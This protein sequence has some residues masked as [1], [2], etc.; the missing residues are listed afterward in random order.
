MLGGRLGSG[1]APLGSAGQLPQAGS[2][3]PSDSIPIAFKFAIIDRLVGESL[4]VIFSLH[5]TVL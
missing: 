1:G 3:G 2:P 4:S 5:F